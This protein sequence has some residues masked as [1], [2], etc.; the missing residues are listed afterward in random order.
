MEFDKNILIISSLVLYLIDMVYISQIKDQY[1]KMIQNIQHSPMKVRISSAIICYLFLI[2]A[3][4]YFI[5]NDQQ[6]TEKDAF[7]LGLSIYGVYD[8]TNYALI[9]KW[10]KNMAIIDTI[11]GGILFYLTTIITK[12]FTKK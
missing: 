9:D 10:D 3:I 4:N 7:I 2:L 8:A 6:K 11:W 12:Q 1:T 5:L